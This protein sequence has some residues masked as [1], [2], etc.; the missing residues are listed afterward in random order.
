MRYRAPPTPRWLTR[1]AWLSVS[2]AVVSLFGLYPLAGGDLTMH[3]VVGKRMWH[4]GAVPRVDP[5][6][7][8]NAGQECIAHSW[9]SEVLFY[10][11]EQSAGTIGLMLLRLGL[12]ILALT[13]ALTTA[14]L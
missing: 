6:S 9:L 3:Q 5:F 13:A 11:I 7:Y 14:R 4:H 10:L 1:L 12:I 2:L 8:V